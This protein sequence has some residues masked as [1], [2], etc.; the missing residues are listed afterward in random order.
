MSDEV[1]G[2]KRLCAYDQWHVKPLVSSRKS[3]DNLHLSASVVSTGCGM[4]L[5]RDCAKTCCWCVSTYLKGFAMHDLYFYWI[6]VICPMICRM[7]QPAILY[8]DV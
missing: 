3:S 6:Q 4:G 7:A 1:F 2:Q 5:F 8:D